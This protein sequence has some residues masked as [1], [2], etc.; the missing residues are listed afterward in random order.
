MESIP[1]SPPDFR[2]SFGGENIDV[3]GCARSARVS[4]IDRARE[5]ERGRGRKEERANERERE[6]LLHNRNE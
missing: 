5:E 3:G 1:V 4:R 6:R 2:A